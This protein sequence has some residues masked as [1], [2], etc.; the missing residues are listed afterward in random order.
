MALQLAAIE[1]IIGRYPAEP[2]S[3]IMVL[4][5]LQTELRH[6]PD[7]AVDLVAGSLGVPRSRVH[8]AVSFYKAFSVA[9]RGKHRIDVCMGTAC[10][11]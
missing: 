2:A 9:P 10:H 3:L 11:V 1:E 5:D 8:S 4:Q 6:V 7:E